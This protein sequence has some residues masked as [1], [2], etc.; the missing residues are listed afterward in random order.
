MLHYKV[1]WEIVTV[2]VLYLPIPHCYN[3]CHT[4]RPNTDT[5]N[6]FLHA[7]CVETSVC[8]P[9]CK[10]IKIKNLC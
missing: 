4:E 8:N 6:H 5:R 2:E 1:K 10:W 9:V 3:V 7:I